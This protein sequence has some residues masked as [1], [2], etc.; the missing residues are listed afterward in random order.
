MIYT[1]D[2]LLHE[3]VSHVNLSNTA[4]KEIDI[5]KFKNIAIPLTDCPC[6]LFIILDQDTNKTPIIGFKSAIK[7]QYG[8]NGCYDL[9]TGMPLQFDELGDKQ[10]SKDAYKDI[11]VYPLVSDIL[12]KN[13]TVYINLIQSKIRDEY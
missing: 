8:N 9:Y 7:D 1:N 13:Y 10:Y 2:I 11:F 5:E 12:K 4:T 6:G 3:V